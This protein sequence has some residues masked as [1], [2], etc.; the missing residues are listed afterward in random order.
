LN[1]KFSMCIDHMM[2]SSCSVLV[3]EG[4]VVS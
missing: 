2:F 3:R 1:I 4:F